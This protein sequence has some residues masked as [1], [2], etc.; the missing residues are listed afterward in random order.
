M[1]FDT[2]QRLL[3]TKPKELSQYITRSLPVKAGAKVK[4]IVQE[5]FRRGGFQNGSTLEKWPLT[6]RQLSGGRSADAQR[7]PLLSSR[8][9]LYNGTGYTPGKAE[10]T[11]YNRVAYAAIH[12][13][14][15]TLHPRVTPA[16]RGH[17]WK[18]Y[19]ELTAGKGSKNGKGSGEAAFWKGLALTKKKTLSIKIPRRRFLG[20][21]KTI[22]TALSTMIEQDLNN[23]LK[24]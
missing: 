17:A 24:A 11:I 14:G 21:S 3:K 18:R 9:V 23:I 16:M 13:E 15:G 8:K 5:N 7:G 10:V 4:S 22:D 6:K 1:D 2:F 19:Y 12:N 20:P